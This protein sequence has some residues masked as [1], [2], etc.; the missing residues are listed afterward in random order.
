MSTL[1]GLRQD[2]RGD[3]IFP[4]VLKSRSEAALVAQTA[5]YFFTN[6]DKVGYLCDDSLHHNRGSSSKSNMGA[7]SYEVSSAENC[8]GERMSIRSC[9]CSCSLNMVPRSRFLG[10]GG[11]DE[12]EPQS[13]PAGTDRWSWW[14]LASSISVSF[15][16]VNSAPL[17]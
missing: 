1:L 4:E 7:F 16:L 17:T 8:S 2:L 13:C 10:G 14:S 11:F 12:D 5:K 3:T 15:T 6:S 9:V